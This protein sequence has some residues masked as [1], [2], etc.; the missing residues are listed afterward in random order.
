MQQQQPSTTKLEDSNVIIFDPSTSVEEIQGTFDRIFYEQ[1]N[2]EMGSERYA[3]YFKPGIYGSPEKPLQLQIGYYTEVAGLGFIP[4]DVRIYGKIEVHNRCFAEKPYDQGLFIP[5]DGTGSVCF[6]LNTFWRS[7]SNLAITIVNNDPDDCRRTAMFWAISQA[8]SMRRAHITGGDVSLMDYCTNPAFASGGYIADTKISGGKIISG[9]QQQFFSR[10]MDIDSWE[11][12]VWN[13]VFMGVVGAPNDSGTSW[14]EEGVPPFTTFPLTPLSREKPYLFAGSRDGEYFVRVPSLAKNARGSSWSNDGRVTPGT[15]LS[16]ALFFI[17][18]PNH[19]VDEINRQ[20]QDGKH[21]VFSPGV[22]RIDSSILVTKA[23][24]VVLG[25]GHATLTAVNGATPIRIADSPGIIVAGVTIDAGEVESPVLLEVGPPGSSNSNNPDNPIT[26]ND[27]YFRLGGPHI[28]RAAVCL[29]INSNHVLVDHTWVWRADHGVENF[30][31]SAGF[32]GDSERWTINTGRNGVVV[33]GD[34]VTMTGLFVEHFQ[35][36]NL[37][38][39]GENGRVYFFQNELPYDPPTQD[40]WMSPGG[41]KGWAAY[42]VDESVQSHELWAGGAYAYNRNNPS[43]VTESGFEVPKR[44][45]VKV[46]RVFTRNLSGPGTIEH[47]VNNEGPLVNSEEK[48][49]QYLNS[50]L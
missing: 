12:S 28:G 41:K 38:W 14:G 32:D 29:E 34:N 44:P 47:I 15:T 20:L 37:L 10:N 46:N 30:D 22:Y 26:L 50:Y 21:L 35:E 13:Q 39:K 1:V 8:S 48:G 23:N 25:L 43:I 9:S 42:K 36:Y 31:K 33:N 45:L 24:T 27:V 6:A 40:D 3:L 2:N 7:L 16:L 19:S 11:G 49:P 18:N 4:D 5:A 17:A